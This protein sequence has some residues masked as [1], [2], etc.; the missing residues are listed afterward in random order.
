MN[1]QNFESIV[2]DL[3]RHQMMEANVREQ[4][5]RHS[6]S[7]GSCAARLRE[8]EGLTQRLRELTVAMRD[9]RAFDETE[10]R[11]V[12]AFREHHAASNGVANA[13]TSAASGGLARSSGRYWRYAAAAA[14]L[15]AVAL[16]L[17]ANRWWGTETSPGAAQVAESNGRSQ[18]AHPKASEEISPSV[19]PLLEAWSYLRE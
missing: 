1:C 6:S 8:E 15:L 13:S 5:Q 2:N 18:S 10:A 12:V 16:G 14:V 19:I 3:A 9:E 7:C 11:L 4:A 17:S